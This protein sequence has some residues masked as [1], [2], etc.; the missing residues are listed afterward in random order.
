[1]TSKLIF[2]L[3]FLLIGFSSYSQEKE[4]LI[5]EIGSSSWIHYKDKNFDNLFKP[6]LFDLGYDLIDNSID[7][8]KVYPIVREVVSSNHYDQLNKK[9]WAISLK[10]TGYGQIVSISF[11]FKDESG[12]DIDEFEILARRIKKEVGCKLTFNKK[13]TDLFYLRGSIMGPKF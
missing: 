4:N 2:S 6:S 9:R 1:M 5:R 3:V 13:V 11:D 12:V 8:G 10:L 7:T